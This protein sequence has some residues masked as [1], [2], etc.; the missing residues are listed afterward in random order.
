MWLSQKHQRKNQ[1]KLK[2]IVNFNTFYFVIQ[3]RSCLFRRFY[4]NKLECKFLQILQIFAMFLKTKLF[5]TQVFSP[6]RGLDANIFGFQRFPPQ[7][8]V[9]WV[10]TS[11]IPVFFV[12]Q[13]CI[14]PVFL[15]PSTTATTLNYHVR[16][17][18]NASYI[19][20]H[21]PVPSQSVVSAFNFA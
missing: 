13:D 15:R 3:K 12:M 18:S 6:S 14:C 20:L 10:N 9:H 11:H 5:L 1:T 4:L 21:M 8:P 7:E 19:S 2:I 17:M 16:Y